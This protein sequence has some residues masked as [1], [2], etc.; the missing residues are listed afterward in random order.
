MVVRGAGLKHIGALKTLESLN[1][2]LCRVT[3]DQL[4]HLAKLTE[5]EN[6]DPRKFASD[7]QGLGQLSELK[8][9]SRLEIKNNKVTDEVVRN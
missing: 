5:L 9:L 2:T 7:L 4:A 1:L 6:V 8:K 3:N